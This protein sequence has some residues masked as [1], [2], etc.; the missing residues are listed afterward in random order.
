MVPFWSPSDG[1][2][3]DRPGTEQEMDQP[4]LA[5]QV[6][7]P[8]PLGVSETSQ[9][10]L[11][12]RE[13]GQLTVPMPGTKSSTDPG[14]DR[15]QMGKLLGATPKVSDKSMAN[16]RVSGQGAEGGFNWPP[17]LTKAMRVRPSASLSPPTSSA[18]A[19]ATAQAQE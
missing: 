18:R 3:I 12:Q 2:M 8:P 10:P 14:I 11:H 15:E 1:V 5:Q 13:V 6:H 19:R 9:V 17:P 16:R 4:P 7:N